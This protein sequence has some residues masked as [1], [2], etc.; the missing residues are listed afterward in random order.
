[1]PTRVHHAGKEK[2]AGDKRLVSIVVPTHNRVG[3]LERALHSVWSQT[4][5]PIELIVVDDGSSDNTPEQIHAWQQAGQA[6]LYIR[7]EEAQGA[8]AAR[9]VGIQRA[10]GQFVALLDDDDAFHP[11]RV[12]RL[13]DILLAH[14]EYA[15]VCSDYLILRRQDSRRSHKPGPIPLKK[16][17][18]MNYAGQPPFA[19]REKLLAVG[20]FD[21]QLTAAQ[22][23][24]L[25]TRLIVAF[26]PGYRLGKVLYFYHQEH[27]APRITASPKKRLYGYYDYYLK[28]KHLM[29][30]SQRAWHLYRLLKLRGRSLSPADFLRM[31]PPRYYALELNDY[32]IHHTSLYQWLNRIRQRATR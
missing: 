8:C 2:D 11:E 14:P 13:V 16:M 22:D 18:W 28:Y 29:N 32:F 17:L 24:D 21:E 27:E 12:E 10:S 7:N 15:F 9:N 25:Y 19:E 5:Q 30:R 26:G 3:L 31:V 4:Y 1:M 6:I 23:Y 20:G